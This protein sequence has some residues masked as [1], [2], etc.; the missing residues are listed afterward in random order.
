MNPVH[1]VEHIICLLLLSLL[2]YA[3]YIVHVL[4]AKVSRLSKIIRFYLPNLPL[5]GYLES[6]PS[7]EE[8]K[9]LY[10]SW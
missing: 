5:R 1:G 9:E 4:E 8:L 7:R 10:E 6:K 2:V 3:G